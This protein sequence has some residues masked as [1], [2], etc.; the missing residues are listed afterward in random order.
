MKSK[1]PIMAVMIFSLLIVLFSGCIEDVSPDPGEITM[2]PDNPQV[3]FSVTIDQSEATFTL[4]GKETKVSRN[5]ERKALFTLNYKNL[6]VG[7]HHLSV[8]DEDSSPREWTI[9]VADKSA[10]NQSNKT[11]AKSWEETYNEWS[12]RAE[13]QMS[14]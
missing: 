2:G 9:H 12:R 11:I 8:Q 6:A 5:E 7:D 14:R 1:L 4:D 3:T 10:T 13:E